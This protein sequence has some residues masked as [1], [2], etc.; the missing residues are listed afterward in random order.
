VSLKRVWIGSPN[1]SSR[2]GSGVRL[3]VLHT[4]EGAQDFRSLGSYFQGPVD[5][6]SHTGIDNKKRGEIGEY[7]K[8]GNN[9]WTQAGANSVS[10]SAELC[11][12]SG[13]AANWSRDYWLNEQRILLDNAADWVAEEAAAFGIPITELSP[14]QAQG[15]GRG[16]CQH[17]DLGSWGGGHS[18]CGS[19]FPIDYVLDK[20]AGGAPEPEPPKPEPEEEEAMLLTGMLDP[21]QTVTVPFPAKS[22]DRVMLFTTAKDTGVPVRCTFHSASGPDNGNSI[23][24]INVTDNGVG[25]TAFPH[26]ETTDVA[27]MTNNGGAKIAWTLYKG[28]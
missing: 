13:A 18:D 14:G 16:V 9:A 10:V 22:F 15:G 1:Y 26:W 28:G 11:T 7:V 23:Q 2:G 24:T 25:G 8:R 17:M 20:A 21:G 19:G 27:T 12:P 5:A 3:I 4:S 6:S